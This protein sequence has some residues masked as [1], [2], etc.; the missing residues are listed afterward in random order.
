VSRS[1]YDPAITAPIVF[2][3]AAIVI[4]AGWLRAGV[5]TD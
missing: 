5:R 3:T 4:G 2:I 1:H